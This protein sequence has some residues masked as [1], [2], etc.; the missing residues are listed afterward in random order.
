MSY[1]PPGYNP[2]DLPGQIMDEGW[3]GRIVDPISG[4]GLF[5]SN[6][7]PNVVGVDPLTGVDSPIG[8]DVG[9]GAAVRRWVQAG[10]YNGDFSVPPTATGSQIEDAYNMLPYW[11]FQPTQ[12][13]QI[14]AFV[15]PATDAG[16]EPT[17]FY[18]VRLFC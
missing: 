6:T 3:G 13:G 14:I 10:V 12:S 8:T 7:D 9:F 17:A 5:T 2:I 1:T 18:A 16:F 11:S 4:A 15:E